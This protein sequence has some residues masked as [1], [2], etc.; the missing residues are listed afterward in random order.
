MDVPLL[1]Y[2]VAMSIDT[3][4]VV[5]RKSIKKSCMEKPTWMSQQLSK[6]LVSG[7]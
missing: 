7:L 4:T 6:K 3:V 1:C 5:L 2:M